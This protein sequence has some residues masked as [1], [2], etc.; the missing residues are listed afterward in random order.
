[1]SKRA[2]WHVSI[3]ALGVSLCG[4]LA[5]WA[6]APIQRLFEPA[7]GLAREARNL[8]HPAVVRSRLV[9]VDPCA[10]AGVEVVRLNLF[11]DVE[12]TAVLTRMEHRSGTQFTWF[13]DL[14]GIPFGQ[15]ILVVEG[16]SLAGHV[17]FPGGVYEIRDAGGGLHVVQEIDQSRFPPE[18]HGVYVDVP[19]EPP[20]ASAG[21]PEDDGSIIDV[22]VVYTPAAAA[23]SSNITAEIQL[24]IAETNQSYQNSG[25]TQRVNLVH[26]EQV[27][28]TETGTLC[29]GGANDLDRLKN[30]SDG[31]LDSVPPMRNT[32]C[33][34]ETVLIVGSGDACG[35][36][37]YTSS[38]S[39]GFSESAYAVVERSCATGYYS[40]GHEMGH[41]MGAQHDW[42]VTP[43]DP[44]G[45]FNHGYVN[46]TARWRT[47]MAYNN[48]CSDAGFNCTRIQ[49]WSN[50]NLTYGGAPLGVPQGSSNAADN[51]ASL[52]NSAYVVSNWRNS[53]SCGGGCSLT[54]TATAPSTGTVGSSVSFSA[55][56]TPVGCTG[57][58]AYAWSFGDGAT[59]S[60][61]NA[62]H[63][64]TAAGTYTWGLTVTVG[65]TTCTKSG[66]I[67]ISG[68]GGCTVTC[69]AT[70]PSSGTAGASVSFSSTSTATGCTG[71]P[72]YSWTFGDGATSSSQNATHA[73]SAAGT[74]T[75][76][77]TVNVG[78]TTCSRSGSIV[79]TGGG[80]SGV[81]VTW[82]APAPGG[83]NPPQNVTAVRTAAD[84]PGPWKQPRESAPSLAIESLAG[85]ARS[86]VGKPAFEARAEATVS[87]SEPNGCIT[88]V[89]GSDPY[90]TLQSGDTLYGA[91]LTSDLGGCL[92]IAHTS[93][94]EY[95]E[96]LFAL[97]IGSSAT[98]TFTL[99]YGGSADLDLY[100]IGLDGGLHLLNPTCGSEPCGATCSNP[101][102][103]SVPLTVGTYVLGVNLAVVYLCSA[104]VDTNY[105]LTITGGSSGPVLQGYNVYRATTDTDG[106]YSQVGPTLGASTLS[107][108]DT[109]APATGTL[110][111]RVRAL[112]D[113]GLSGW[114]NTATVGG[115]GSCT[116]TCTASAPTSANT[117]VSVAFTGSATA[118]GCSGS[119]SY[120][121]SFGDGAT[122]TSQ[123]ATHAY[124]TSGTYNW[125]FTASAGGQSCT[126]T[127]SIVVSS[128]VTPPSVT[129]MQKLGNPFRIKAFG[130]NL[131][132]GIRVFIDGV[133]WGNVTWKSPTQLILKGG[134]SLKAVVPKYTTH[135]FRFLNPD[136]GEMS[137]TWGWP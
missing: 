16:T 77:L 62:T 112:Y 72:S 103:F 51:H 90:Q 83:A 26:A 36:A 34:D 93:G 46:T 121:W 63:A 80:G 14:E 131:Q 88:V 30:P 25:I 113:T 96:D 124:S 98:Y 15:A 24:A 82:S 4:A 89:G 75:W 41:N 40:F 136:G 31:Y 99:S 52:N 29:G 27:S 64:Y 133:E 43:G 111:Y 44:P 135:T 115:G 59:S 123:N 100:L 116:V 48:Q 134:A 105:T 71:S 47:V 67:V 73:Y 118:S 49:Y 102:T 137:G 61:Q 19:Q 114:S 38:P 55:T 68:G 45:S 66:T 76:T 87:E 129:A 39:A 78:G 70:V 5:A 95:L 101:E 1:M 28:Y 8:D 85:F 128:P 69:A 22:L 57:S 92:Y 6:G 18:S 50:P 42:Y 109:A 81:L 86:P 21:V 13:G 119:P 132:P 91:A 79:V 130:S 125:T 120:L 2:V 3:L 10:L 97:S 60:S 117:G 127:G 106:A 23:A 53:A 58:P 74:Y 126:R 94:N 12:V 122:S 107:Y 9:R 108:T 54:C 11:A 84:A 33:A 20:R 7:V 110:Y 37:Y 17:A 65:S 56:A 35:C 32:Y 104:P